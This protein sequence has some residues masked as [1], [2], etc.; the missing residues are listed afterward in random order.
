MSAFLPLVAAN[1]VAV[2]LFMVL[3]AAAGARLMPQA[4]F[5]AC[6]ILLFALATVGWVR[7]E[8]RHR[9][10]DPL[11]RLGRAA[12][13]LLGACL[14]AVLLVLLPVFSLE[15]RL[16]SEAGFDRFVAPSM[17][18]VLAGLVLTALSNVVGGIV[19]ALVALMGRGRRR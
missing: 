17:V 14:G 6:L 1:L 4:A 18:L 9:G 16:P 3:Y 5:V 11:A 10:L 13:G 19:A 12:V 2:V 7:V 15:T 8:A